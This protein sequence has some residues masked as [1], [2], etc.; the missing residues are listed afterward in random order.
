[1]RSVFL[2]ALLLGL[3]GCDDDP[4]TAP[5]SAPTAAHVP[6]GRPV[7]TPQRGLLARLAADP[8]VRTEMI[9][10]EQPRGVVLCAIDV[11]GR[12]EGERYAWL[13][14]GNYRTGPQAALLSASAEPAVIRRE[15]V[16][17]PRQAYLD[18]DIDRLFPL[19]VAHAI[20]YRDFV[21]Q[22]S[23]EELLDLAR[24]IAAAPGAAPSR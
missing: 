15:G 9:G 1:M 7:T 22:P 17:F 16:E 24:S 12:A 5:T 14:C 10:R 20:R 18:D 8:V 6:N 23:D 2:I 19:E 11:L 21:T 3:A 13:M 4:T